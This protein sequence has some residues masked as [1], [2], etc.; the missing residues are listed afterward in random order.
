[1]LRVNTHNEKPRELGWSLLP[2]GPDD[3]ETQSFP[4]PHPDLAV[5][6]HMTVV[7][8][9]GDLIGHDADYAD[10]SSLGWLLVSVNRLGMFENTEDIALRGLALKFQHRQALYRSDRHSVHERHRLARTITR[11][12]NLPVNTR[13]C[14]D[15]YVTCGQMA[16]FLR[17]TA[18]YLIGKQLSTQANGGELPAAS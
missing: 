5:G 4:E 16:A 8:E 6:Y 14:P 11:G 1:M 2:F 15:D 17:R 9:K 7:N 12:C 18:P 10:G 3:P 13:F